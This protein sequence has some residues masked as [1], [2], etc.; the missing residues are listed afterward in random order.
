MIIGTVSFGGS[1]GCL[2]FGEQE[3]MVAALLA[4]HPQRVAERRAVLFGLGS[5]R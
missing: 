3:T 1:A 5:K 4:E 2:L